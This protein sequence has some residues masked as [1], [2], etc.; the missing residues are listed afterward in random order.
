MEGVAVHLALAE[1]AAIEAEQGLLEL[2]H[3]QLQV[4][5]LRLASVIERQQILEIPQ[6][7]LHGPLLAL[8]AIGAQFQG[9]IPQPPLRL[10]HQG[11][12]PI[13]AVDGNA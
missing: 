12:G 5:G 1:Q 2:A 4:A 8:G 7:H 13:A 10:G 6:G 11:L 9:G 3:S